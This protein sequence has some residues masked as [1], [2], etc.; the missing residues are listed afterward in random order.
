MRSFRTSPR[1]G[2]KIAAS[3]A[4]TATGACIGTVG[5]SSVASALPSQG[6]C[7]AGS[8]QVSSGVCEAIFTSTGTTE[9]P[10]PAGVSSLDVLTVGGGGGGAGSSTYASG[11][12]GGGGQVKVCTTQVVDAT[13]TLE[14]SVGAGGAGSAEG[15]DTSAPG[16]NGSTSEVTNGVW[17]CIANGG[18]GGGG[19]YDDY[20]LPTSGVFAAGGVS[21]SGVS[22]GAGVTASPSFPV[23]TY[24]PEYEYGTFA[25]SGGGGDSQVGGTWS[26]TAGGSG[27]NGTDPTAGLFAGSGSTYGGGGGGGLY[28]QYVTND[29]GITFLG[30]PAPGGTGGGGA[31]GFDVSAPQDGS[32]N[33]GG[34]GG[35]GSTYVFDLGA[36]GANGGSGI[37]IVRYQLSQSPPPVTNIYVTG[38]ANSVTAT[39]TP[40][41]GATSYT[42]T[43]LYGFNSPSNFTWNV[44]SPTCTFNGLA[45]STEYGVSVVANGPGGSSAPLVGFA[46][47]LPAPAPVTPPSSGSGSGGGPTPPPVTPSV[48]A[49]I[50]FALNKTFLTAAAKNTLTSLAN[51]VVADNITHLSVVGFAD[52]TGPLAHN[53]VLSDQRAAVAAQFLRSLFAARGVTVTLS[54]TGDGVLSK[55]PNNAYNR[56]VIVTN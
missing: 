20:V 24:A 52:P 11:G 40:S 12:G 36:S 22:G 37:V 13:Q 42:C 10:V 29:G 32:M 19:A 9:W 16:G 45:P 15:Y 8:F 21:G 39:W 27:G 46:E 18:G 34:G 55:Y 50:Y 43:L 53:Q 7:P 31:G 17:N 33:S 35:G 54:V 5:V 23:D 38:G 3:I 1:S 14:V 28:D 51:A 26:T 44:T 41:A 4:L 25:A 49:H 2:T 48:S 56:V 6:N 30:S 47:T